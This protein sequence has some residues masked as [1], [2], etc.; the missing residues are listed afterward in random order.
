MIGGLLLGPDRVG[1]G[2]LS[3]L[4]GKDVMFAGQLRQFRSLSPFP[5][6]VAISSIFGG[7]SRGLYIGVDVQFPASV[8]RSLRTVC[9]AFQ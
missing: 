5:R 4:C 8:H 6:V 7:A 1:A 3:L 2:Q 9:V